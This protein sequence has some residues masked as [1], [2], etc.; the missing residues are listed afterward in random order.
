[1]AKNQASKMIWDATDF[2]ERLKNVYAALEARSVLLVIFQL[3]K[4]TD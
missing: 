3:I 4:A 2:P 1:M